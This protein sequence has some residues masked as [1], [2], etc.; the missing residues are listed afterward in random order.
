MSSM[1]LFA[2]ANPANLPNFFF[3]SLLLLLLLILLV[4]AWRH[5]LECPDFRQRSSLAAGEELRNPISQSAG[6][7]EKTVSL[8]GIQPLK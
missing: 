2:L 5:Q 3:L 8:L 7:R 4:V 6:S 1:C